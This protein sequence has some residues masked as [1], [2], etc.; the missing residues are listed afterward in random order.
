MVA[1]DRGQAKTGVKGVV[2]CLVPCCLHFCPPALSLKWTRGAN[3]YAACLPK[4]FD[5]QGN[6]RMPLST[7]F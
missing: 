7:E 4:D 3:F 5:N 2:A 1:D 6:S